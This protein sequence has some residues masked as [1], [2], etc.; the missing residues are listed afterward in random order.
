MPITVAGIVTDASETPIADARVEVADVVGSTDPDGR[1]S[2][3]VRPEDPPTLEGRRSLRVTRVGY[4]PRAIWVESPPSNAIHVVLRPAGVLVGAVM[5]LEGRSI[6]NARVSV[7]GAPDQWLPPATMATGTADAAG[8]F[9]FENVADETLEIV[10]SAPGHATDLLYVSASGPERRVIV[11]LPPG[12]PVTARVVDE[13]GSPVSGAQLVTRIDTYTTDRAGCSPPIWL[14]STD[15]LV[16]ETRHPAFE[17]TWMEFSP[18]ARDSHCEIRLRRTRR[19]QAVVESRA[20]VPGPSETRWLLRLSREDEPF[21]YGIH[22]VVPPTGRVE[23]RLHQGL[24]PYRVTL[25]MQGGH[26]GL[27]DTCESVVDARF[28]VSPTTETVSW[29]VPALRPVPVICQDQLGAPVPGATVMMRE[30]ATTQPTACTTVTDEKGR[31]IAWVPDGAYVVWTAVRGTQAVTA[32]VTVSGHAVPPV[33]LSLPLALSIEGRLHRSDGSPVADRPV[34]ANG[35]QFGTYAMTDHR[36]RFQF[37][38]LE[39]GRYRIEVMGES[40]ETW[41]LQVDNVEVPNSGLDLVLDAD[42]V[43]GRVEGAPPVPM[44]VMLRRLPGDAGPEGWTDRSGTFEFRAVAHGR[45]RALAESGGQLFTWEGRVSGPTEV[46]L[47]AAR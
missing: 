32:R 47:R 7:R 2:L 46:V 8:E 14:P 40:M 9:R 39:T 5:D 33:T 44:R 38:G 20:G 11:V 31:T 12:N 3:G 35:P 45:W 4:A 41:G 37:R 34:L 29:A 1:F 30:P 28:V 15:A 27:A 17:R 18:D 19:L 43:R 13:G 25:A 26:L 24:V 22:V 6:P 23:L 10:V 21:G 16:L 42:V 36:G